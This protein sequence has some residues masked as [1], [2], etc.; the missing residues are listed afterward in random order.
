[1]YKLGKR[2][3]KELVGVH[4]M[5]AFV[6]MEAI[7]ITKQDF[8]V[9]DGVR[10]AKE[11]RK[12]VQRGVSKTNNSYH[13]YGGA[14]D[15][16]AFVKGKPTWDNKYYKEIANAVKKV[17]KKH[18]IVGID[19]GYDLWKWDL[20]HWQITK[21]DGVDARKVYDIRKIDPTKF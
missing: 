18:N 6:A 16:V 19:W 20:A 4:P 17:I 3:K 21:I 1:M 12:L 13:L 8:M 14:M 9:F 7:K 5:L 15:L 11:Q 2:S 10:T